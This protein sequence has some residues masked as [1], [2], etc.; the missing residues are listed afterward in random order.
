[1]CANVLRFGTRAC[2]Q[3]KYECSVWTPHVL[4]KQNDTRYQNEGR[5]SV[6]RLF[7]ALAC[8]PIVA[9]CTPCRAC[10][11][12]CGAVCGVA[13][14]PKLVPHFGLKI[15]PQNQAR[16]TYLRIYDYV[17]SCTGQVSAGDKNNLKC[18]GGFRLKVL[19]MLENL[20][21]YFQAPT[22]H[23]C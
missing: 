12:T 14:H 2:D 8:I 21:C 23:R 4:W 7:G 11:A 17:L 5:L 13:R 20:H 15:S 22:L 1:M 19:Q 6:S 3:R 10:G 16:G 18:C 9:R